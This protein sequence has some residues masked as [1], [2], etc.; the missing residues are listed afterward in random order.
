MNHFY[1]NSWTKFLHRPGLAGVSGF[2]LEGAAPLRYL[3]AQALLASVP[4]W[5][6][7]SRASLTSF[8]EMMEDPQESREFLGYFTEGE[9][10]HGQ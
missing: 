8:A 1:W 4:F 6:P 9:F 7:D 5:K 10:R 2:L 3:A